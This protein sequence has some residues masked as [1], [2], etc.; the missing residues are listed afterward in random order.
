MKAQLLALSAAALL[1][2]SQAH[3]A[4][5][6]PVQHYLDDTR[7]AALQRLQSAGV[8][9]SGQP[10]MIR[11]VVRS[12]G[13]LDGLRVVGTTGSRD[14]DDAIAEALRKM[15]G[16]D[17]PAELAGRELTLTLGGDLVRAANR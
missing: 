4:A 15:R 13:R 14:K 17:A 6:A 1:L 5:S 8:D 7:A 10:A 11:A 3:A 12:D 16:P 9:L 2:A